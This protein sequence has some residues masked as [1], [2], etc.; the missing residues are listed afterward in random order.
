MFIPTFCR[1]NATVGMKPVVGAETT[2]FVEGSSSVYDVCQSSIEVKD[3]A[4]IIQGYKLKGNNVGKR[5][6]RVR[7]E[8][9]ALRLEHSPN[10]GQ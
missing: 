10:Q 9:Q 4:S 7:V 8:T 6:N 3:W 2:Q 5:L 1:R